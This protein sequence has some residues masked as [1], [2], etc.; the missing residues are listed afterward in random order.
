M[1]LKDLFVIKSMGSWYMHMSVGI[2]R[3]QEKALDFWNYR[4]L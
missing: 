1:I 3:G 4:Q 2:Q